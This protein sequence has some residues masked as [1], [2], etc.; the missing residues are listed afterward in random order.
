MIDRPGLVIVHPLPQDEDQRARDHRRDQQ[1]HPVHGGEAVVLHA[2]DQNRHEQRNDD[3]ARQEHRGEQRRAPQAGPHQ[4][5]VQRLDIV[6]EAD[7]VRRV[8][9]QKLEIGEADPDHA[10]DRP[11][12]VPDE[13]DERRQQEGPG[14]DLLLRV[15]PCGRPRCAL[16]HVLSRPRESGP[17]RKR[18]RREQYQAAG[19]RRP[20]S[21]CRA[22][23]RVGR[24]SA[25]PARR[26]PRSA[27][28]RAGP[29][30][31]PSDR[32]PTPAARSRTAASR[33]G[34]C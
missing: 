16:C 7:P 29:A 32:S 14:I 25:R 8:P 6:G 20:C 3:G 2:V 4:R 26:R 31:R 1:D 17:T 33:T 18:S 24:A 34:G 23:F 19:A 22:S 11:G 12:L 13:E 9:A 15:L 21:C 27:S 5:I 28:R 10:D 30:P